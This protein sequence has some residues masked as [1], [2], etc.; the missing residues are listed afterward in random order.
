MAQQAR[1]HELI[2]VL[3]GMP[4]LAA[5]LVH[6]HQP[7][8]HGRCGAG[9]RAGVDGLAVIGV[10]A[11]FLLGVA[12]GAGFRFATDGTAHRVPDRRRVV[13]PVSAPRDATATTRSRWTR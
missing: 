3:V 9:C 10:T 4:R 7:D 12:V 5:D 11:A 8:E 2:D 6:D 13:L 1:L